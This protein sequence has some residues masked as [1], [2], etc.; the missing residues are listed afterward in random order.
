MINPTTGRPGLR[1]VAA[2]ALM[3]ASLMLAGLVLV[4]ASAG[5]ASAETPADTPVVRI[6]LGHGG[7]GFSA[8]G[9]EVTSYGRGHIV[10]GDAGLVVSDVSVYSTTRGSLILRDGLKLRRGKRSITIK[11]ILVSV[12]QGRVT[13]TG[14]IGGR[15]TVLATGSSGGA[16]VDAGRIAVELDVNRLRM[17]KRGL[18][19]IRRDL[20][21][22]KPRTRTLG[23]MSGGGYVVAPPSGGGPTVDPGTATSCHP[24]GGPPADPSRP[25]GATDIGCGFVNWNVRDSWIVYVGNVQA[26]APGAALPAYP[27]GQHACPTVGK[28]EVKAYSY[29]LPVQSGW[30]NAADSTGAIFTDGGMYFVNTGHGIDIRITR[31]EI[32]INGANTQIWAHDVD[33]THPSGERLELA[34]ANATAPQSGGPI[35]PGTAMT[36][37]GTNLTTDG[38]ELIGHGFYGVGSS[39]GCID[40][41]FDF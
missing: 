10:F 40:M 38:D 8:P 36:R 9:V 25:P 32:R 18:R 2:N 13:M 7:R 41:G 34:T 14:R 24:V 31:I 27:G 39:F 23:K 33:P 37:I 11:G 15:R 20:G 1:A 29:S 6:P 3:L 5:E 4:L 22:F 12:D 17:S 35:A 19:A 28:T 16:A 26:V 30:W 21:Q